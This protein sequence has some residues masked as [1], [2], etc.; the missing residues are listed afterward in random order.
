MLFKI[1]TKHRN[2]IETIF[3]FF[4]L[5]QYFY[6]FILIGHDKGNKI[7]DTSDNIQILKVR[8]DKLEIRSLKKF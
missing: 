4:F 5:K 8:I 1:L 2:I 3:G 7:I 6:L